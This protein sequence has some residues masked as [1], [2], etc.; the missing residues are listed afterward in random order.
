MYGYVPKWYKVPAK[1]ALLGSDNALS[2]SEQRGLT[3]VESRLPQLKQDQQL[4][5]DL[6]ALGNTLEGVFDERE[7]DSELSSLMKAKMS[8]DSDSDIYDYLGLNKEKIV[9]DVESYTGNKC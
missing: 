8:N 5:I 9:N 6:Q 3:L 1:A 7:N 2:Y 4:K